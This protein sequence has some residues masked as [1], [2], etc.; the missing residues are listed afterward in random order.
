[1][2]LTTITPPAIRPKVNSKIQYTQGETSI[3]L[4]TCLL[5]AKPNTKGSI[6]INIVAI[7]TFNKNNNTRKNNI[8][9]NAII[10]PSPNNWKNN[11]AISFTAT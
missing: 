11:V 9:T 8:T 3:R 1:M 7:F 6:T 2:A 5:K 10:F 4:L